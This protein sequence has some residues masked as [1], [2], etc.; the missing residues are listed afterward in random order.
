MRKLERHPHSRILR[1]LVLAPSGFL[2]DE[3]ENSSHAPGVEAGSLRCRARGARRR[4]A[5]QTQQIKPKL[6]G[7][8]SR[9]VRQFI[10]ER[11]EDPGKCVAARR[12]QR[13]SGNPERHQRSTEEKV[14][15]ELTRKLVPRNIG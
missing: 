7:I 15:R 11:L 9:G 8:L 10:N 5:R 14:R 6:N 3:L 1:E 12:T 2:R 13:V 4:E